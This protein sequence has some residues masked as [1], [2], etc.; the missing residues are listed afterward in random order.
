MS[1]WSKKGIKTEA[2]TL[3]RWFAEHSRPLPWRQ[4][5]DPYRIWISEIMLQQTTVKAVIPYFKRFMERFPSVNDLAAAPLDDVYSHWAG[6]GYYSR[7]RNLHKAAQQIQALPTFPQSFQELLQLPGLGDYASRAISSQAFGEKVGVVDGNVIRVL[8]RRF[9]LPVE[10]WKNK[11]KKVLQEIADEYAQWADPG[12]INQAFMELGATLC[13]PTTPTCLLCPLQSRCVAL[14]ED[15]VA[16]LPLKKPKRAM[17]IWQWNVEIIEHRGRIALIKNQYAPFL[18]QQLL[19]PGEAMKKTAAP[20][21]FDFQ[22][23]VTH[24][25]IYVKVSRR[26]AN[27]SSLAGHEITWLSPSQLKK[28]VPFALVRKAIDQGLT[29]TER[30]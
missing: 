29:E 11:E 6:L 20:E 9:G 22:H 15:K 19:P 5:Q 10:H 2:R 23:A 18:K 24:H 28:K 16:E 13:S 17:E 14:K 4:N 3:V 25:K 8:S 1:F 21:T 26:K 27:P 30:Y 12:Q 7:A